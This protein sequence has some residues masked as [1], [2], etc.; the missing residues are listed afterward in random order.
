MSLT[1]YQASPLG[2]VWSRR[3]LVL[4]GAPSRNFAM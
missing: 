2:L 3:L 1:R 4:V